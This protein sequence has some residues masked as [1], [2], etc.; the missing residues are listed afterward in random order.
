MH[1]KE[2]LFQFILSLIANAIYDCIKTWL[3]AKNKAKH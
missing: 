3:V 1:V 2:I